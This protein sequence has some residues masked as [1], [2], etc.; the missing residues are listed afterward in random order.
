MS[1]LVLLFSHQLTE[2]HNIDATKRAGNA[3]VIALT[4]S[5]QNQWGN[6]PDNL[7]SAV[8][9]QVAFST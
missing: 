8:N 2:Q 7:T 3:E 6:V 1:K 4:A 9:N 5:L